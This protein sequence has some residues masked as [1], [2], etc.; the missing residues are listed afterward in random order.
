MYEQANKAQ[1]HSQLRLYLSYCVRRN[2]AV[3]I[4]AGVFE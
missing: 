3:Y 1:L 4:N 2:Y